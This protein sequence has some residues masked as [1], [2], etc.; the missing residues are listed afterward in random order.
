MLV[1]LLE[2]ATEE[3]QCVLTSFNP[4]FAAIWTE[5]D[6]LRVYGVVRKVRTHNELM[7]GEERDGA[8]DA[9]HEHGPN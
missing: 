1:K 5:T 9:A 2:R 7:N 3:G 4:A 8:S 6:A